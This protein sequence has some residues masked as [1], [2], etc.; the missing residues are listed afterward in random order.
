MVLTKSTPHILVCHMVYL[1][2]HVY[3]GMKHMLKNINEE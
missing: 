1:K 3:G 2:K